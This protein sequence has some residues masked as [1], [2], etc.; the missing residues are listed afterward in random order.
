[1]LIA[2]LL[3]QHALAFAPDEHTFIGQ[4]PVRVRRYHPERQHALRRSEGWVSFTEGEGAGWL[5]RFDERTGTAHRAWGPSIELGDPQTTEEAA[6]AVLALLE[7]YPA[8][9]GVAVAELVLGDS[10]FDADSGT[11]FIQLDRVVRSSTDDSVVPDGL[12]PGSAAQ[13]DVWRGGVSAHIKAGRLISFGIDTHPAASGLSLAP[14]LTAATAIATAIAGG[15]AP[16]S[17]HSDDSAALIVLPVEQGSGIAYRLC[18]EVR[19]TTA[20]P[21]GQWVTFVDAQ[22]GALLNIHNE[23]R[24]LSGDLYAAHDTRTVNGD[25]S[26]SP[27]G[28]VFLDAADGSSEVAED[29]T[30]A[31][32][33]EVIASLTS[34][35]VRVRDS[36]VTATLSLVDGENT[37]VAGDTTQ[38]EIDT[39]VFLHQVRDWAEAYAP[40]V[41]NSWSR[42]TS[43]VNLDSS[44]NAYFDGEVNFYTAGSG[45]NNTARI[46]DVNY[47]EWGHGFHYYNLL[48]GSWDGSISEGIG[49]SVAFF[50]TGDSVISPYFYNSGSGIRDASPDRVYPEDW[51]GEVH[52]DGLIF[53]GAVW[54]LWGELE[55]ELGA[56]AAEAALFPLFVSA[57][58]GGPEIPDAYDEFVAADDDNGDL[59]D[60][61]PNLCAIIDAFSRHGLGPGGNAA[62]FNLTTAPVGNQPATAAE[63]P[64][65]ADLLN[66]AEGCSDF[67]IETA[68][69]RYSSDG[70]ESWEATL[71]SGAQTVTGA[72]PAQVAGT[73]VLYYVAAV[74]MEGESVTAP[75]GGEITPLSFYV[76][77]LV[78]L[79]CNDFES[80][81][82]GFTSALLAGEASSGAD[83]WMWGTPNGMGGDPDFAYSGDKVWGNDLGGTIDGESYNGEYQNDKHN[84]LTTPPIETQGYET[85]V[86]QFQRWLSVEDGYYDQASVLINDDLV[87]EN[88]STEYDIGDEHH[89]DSQWALQTIQLDAAGASDLTISWEIVS[90][91][92]LSMGGWNVDDVCV[93]GVEAP[94]PEGELESGGEDAVKGCG[95]TSASQP[96]SLLGLLWIAGVALLRRRD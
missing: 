25:M 41:N 74:S 53:A 31:L 4:E 88:H 77:E 3:G 63:Y 78:E 8:L 72:I 11:W 56:E 64:V 81:D 90:D 65:E 47:H 87:W 76:G 57:L 93:Y 2:L 96:A 7:R 79:Y 66:L 80:D 40:Q 19:S 89:Q 10:G 68:E 92:G 28:G 24:F 83:D 85:V 84:Q 42:I 50:L 52:Y 62:L 45:C 15:P 43:N 29:G 21:V 36:N 39:Y 18:W 16:Y 49:D 70:G 1:M 30:W 37:W 73:E 71:L 86:V 51:I 46:A 95:C 91:A 9:V 23:V 58:R 75:A 20:V 61:T 33:G 27:L 44:C 60:G 69:V 6:E 35:G 82:G 94:A 17:P 55:D 12:T 13:V 54:D 59:S 67:T 34:D 5:A 48:S 38:A 32:E 14:T 22:T 26:T